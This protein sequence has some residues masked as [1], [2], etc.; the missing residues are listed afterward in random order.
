MAESKTD[1]ESMDPS[2]V[3]PGQKP[4]HLK[5]EKTAK[6]NQQHCKNAVKKGC[7]NTHIIEVL[8]WVWPQIILDY[9]GN[10]QFKK[11][12]LNAILGQLPAIP[13]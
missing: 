7:K 11:G 2:S 9:F 3:V 1:K 5:N 4:K 6:P 10:L 12:I 13:K 8:Q